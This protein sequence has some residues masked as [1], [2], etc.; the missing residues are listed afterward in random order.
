[1]KCLFAVLIVLL[2]EK[3]VVEKSF[4]FSDRELKTTTTA[5]GHV[6]DES[7]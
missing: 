5:A 2:Y 7:K 6:T 4:L 1:M 3:I